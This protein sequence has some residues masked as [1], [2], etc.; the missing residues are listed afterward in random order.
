METLLFSEAGGMEIEEVDK[1]QIKV[2]QIDPLVGLQN[3]QLNTVFLRTGLREEI[4][5]KAREMVQKLYSVFK[6]NRLELLEINPLVVTPAGDLVCL[7]AKI[8]VDDSLMGKRD[9]TATAAPLSFEE[10][11]KA[12]GIHG[13]ELDGDIAV[14]ASGA[15]CGLSTIDTIKFHGGTI[16]AFVDLGPLVHDREK[17]E[18]VVKAVHE[19]K[20]KVILFNFYFQVA[21][22]ENLANSIVSALQEIPVVVRVKGRYEEEARSLLKLNNCEVTGDFRVAVAKALELVAGGKD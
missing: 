15:G 6:T 16:R 19:L 22:C 8:V 13:V 4:K 17:A 2:I 5:A 11:M 3:Y 12:L 1:N 7:D 18:E 14:V 20:P 21:S 10:K 9:K